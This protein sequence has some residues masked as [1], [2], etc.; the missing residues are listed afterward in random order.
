[1]PRMIRTVATLCFGLVVLCALAVVPVQAEP[2]QDTVDRVL[3]RTTIR[4]LLSESPARRM[5]GRIRLKLLDDEGTKNLKK[6]ILRLGFQDCSNLISQFIQTDSA[7]IPPLLFTTL[8][9]QDKRVRA[10]VTGWAVC[11]TPKRIAE[12][13]TNIDSESKSAFL[14]I[15]TEEKIL[16]GLCASIVI[17]RA[18]TQQVLNVVLAMDLLLGADGLQSFLTALVDRM[19]GEDRAGMSPQKRRR[20][21]DARANASTVFATTMLSTTSL[22]GYRASESSDSRKQA[23]EKIRNTI[24]G[25]KEF[26]TTPEVKPTGK[27][28]GDW[29]LELAKSSDINVRAVAMMRLQWWKG[30]TKILDGVEREAEIRKIN[31]LSRRARTKLR[32]KLANWWHELRKKTG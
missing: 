6:E 14:G 19:E 11:L 7:K 9:H 25:W 15:L 18:P 13:V 28:Y 29:L 31:G 32:K 12:S 21:A 3:A 2:E 17:E 22:H 10:L 26:T 1:M 20:M 4:L 30:D 5:S 24:K 8:R 27:R 16:D 23:V